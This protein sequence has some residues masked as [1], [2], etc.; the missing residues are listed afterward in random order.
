MES[1]VKG[2]VKLNNK[3]L[4]NKG[5]V[6]DLIKEELDLESW[7]VFQKEEVIKFVGVNEIDGCA[8]ESDNNLY[9]LENEL[10]KYAD[11]VDIELWYL[12]EDPDAVIYKEH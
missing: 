4:E 7:Q 1:I 8:W 5:K 10:A 2:I 11:L 6:V 3:G 12:D 9:E